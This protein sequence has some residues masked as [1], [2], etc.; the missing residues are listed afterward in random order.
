MIMESDKSKTGNQQISPELQQKID[1]VL[2]KV[3][4]KIDASGL[5][6]KELNDGSGY[7]GT[8]HTSVSFG[9]RGNRLQFGIKDS[10]D[11]TRKN[12]VGFMCSNEDATIIKTAVDNLLQD[13]Y[14]LFVYKG[15]DVFAELDDKKLGF[16]IRKELK[17]T[18]DKFPDEFAFKE[19][20][21]NQNYICNIKTKLPTK[22]RDNCN[23]ELT[24]SIRPSG[25]IENSKKDFS[26]KPAEITFAIGTRDLATAKAIE[27]RVAN[28]LKKYGIIEHSLNNTGL[29][30]SN[31]EIPKEWIN[32]N[33]VRVPKQKIFFGLIVA[34]ENA[35]EKIPDIRIKFS[36]ISEEQAEQIKDYA[37]NELLPSYLNGQGEKPLTLKNLRQDIETKFPE[38][39]VKKTERLE[40][41]V[42]QRKILSGTKIK[43]Q[44]FTPSILKGKTLVEIKIT[45]AKKNDGLPVNSSSMQIQ[46]NTSN[47]ALMQSRAN[48]LQGLSKV[49]LEDYFAEHLDT[50]IITEPRFIRRCGKEITATVFRYKKPAEVAPAGKVFFEDLRDDKLRP[51]YEQFNRY[52][53]WETN[54][55]LQE[56]GTYKITAQIKRNKDAESFP[57]NDPILGKTYYFQAK[58]E[59]SATEFCHKLEENILRKE[60]LFSRE[61]PV[62][63]FGVTSMRVVARE[64]LDEAIEQ[65]PKITKNKFEVTAI[66]ERCINPNS[67]H[68]QNHIGFSRTV[69]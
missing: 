10:A 56:D 60:H 59:Q 25:D 46:L 67:P 5:D 8:Y 2:Q 48:A 28:L 1:V 3:R 23:I 13:E 19:G 58:D 22:S 55:A 4:A 20:K 26:K 16:I 17:K 68:I 49:V 66:H 15:K 51:A 11:I 64:S 33:K 35:A 44:L 36:N 31:K 32:L 61:R 39:F 21:N 45:P 52:I 65:S 53:Y 12:T 34:A 50:E 43:A 18:E 7:R 38:F 63:R 29:K 41:H 9:D 27:R 37:K 57:E 69:I 40:A 54:A 47:V 6:F 42:D 14:H 30:D 62:E 24:I